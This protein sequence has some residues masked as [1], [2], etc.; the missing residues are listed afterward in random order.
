VMHPRPDHPRPHLGNTLD[1]TPTTPR[2]HL[3]Y[4]LTI[5]SYPL[6][7]PQDG[8]VEQV[9]SAYSERPC[10]G[11][12]P[13]SA[14]R[15]IFLSGASA[16]DRCPDTLEAVESSSM[17][18]ERTNRQRNVPPKWPVE[19]AHI[20]RCRA[21]TSPGSAVVSH[22]DSRTL[23]KSRAYRGKTAGRISR[24]ETARSAGGREPS[25]RVPAPPGGGGAP[26]SVRAGRDGGIRVGKPSARLGP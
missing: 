23:E 22:S 2:P 11:T 26:D 25:P 8:R 17:R 1:H 6:V 7:T 24:R 20:T 12:P 15:T 18:P 13:R 10:E 21:K 5:S 16:G 3:G 4:T 14:V 9:P 19:R